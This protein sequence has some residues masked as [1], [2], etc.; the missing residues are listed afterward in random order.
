MR[1]APRKK[2]DDDDIVQDPDLDEAIVVEEDESAAHGLQGAVKKLR[3][4]LAKVRKERD[5]NLAGWQR[6]RADLVNFRRMVEEDRAREAA[7]AKA[8]LL[9]SLIAVMD[10]FEG[11]M[12]SPTW[13]AVDKEWR[14]GVERIHGQLA[15]VFASQDVVG[16]AVEGDPF[17]PTLH[18]CMS[19]VATDDPAKDHTLAQVFQRGYRIGEEVVRPAKVVVAQTG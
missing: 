4:E 8:E 17:D 9:R 14:E 16:F 15:K 19:V 5:D 11:A 2:H 10:S 1:K 3:S 7:R 6:S 18:E 12:S 13:E